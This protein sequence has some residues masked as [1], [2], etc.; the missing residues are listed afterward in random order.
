MRGRV[1]PGDPI[2]FLASRTNLTDGLLTFFFAA[3][4]L[5]G[6][7]AILRR[8][9][10]RRWLAWGA[11]TGAAAAGA[12][13]TKGLIALALPGAILLLWSWASGRSAHFLPLVLSPAPLVFLALTLPWLLLAES[14]IPGFL[15]LFFVREHLQR[16]ATGAARRPGPL[17]YFVP[18]FLLGFL[19]GCRSSR[20]PR[21]ASGGRFR[22]FSI[23]SG[24]AVR[25]S[26]SKSKLPP[27]LFPAIPAARRLPRCRERRLPRAHAAAV[28]GSFRPLWR[29]SRG[30][31]LLHPVLRAP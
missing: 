4:V 19:P 24:F 26:I 20:R 28:A 10:G 17:L 11:W 16:F 25:L 3:T 29:R 23:S 9:A 2:G 13:L 1:V 27:Y 6:R 14:R 18:V 8:A 21:R 5:A 15:H 12:F 31:L 30:A 7:E 22:R